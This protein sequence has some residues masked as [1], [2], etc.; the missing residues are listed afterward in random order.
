[1][2]RQRHDLPEED[3][4]TLKLSAQFLRN[5]WETCR[6]GLLAKTDRIHVCPEFSATP[7]TFQFKIQR[8]FKSKLGP[9]APVL[10]EPGPIQGTII[11]RRDLFLNFD[12]PSVAVV[13]DPY[14]HYFHPNYS[15]RHGLLC[16]GELPPGPFPLDV[17]IENHLF[18]ILSYQNRRPA[19]PA[20]L[21]AARY[22][23]LDPDAMEGLE[24]VEPLY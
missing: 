12:E 16:L 20:D 9:D 4:P 19:H 10:V 11:Y 21:E 8:P 13:L 2:A 23:A 15:R 18:P 7:R 17:L 22:F 5:T 14:Q 3:T 1:L 6:D 24:P